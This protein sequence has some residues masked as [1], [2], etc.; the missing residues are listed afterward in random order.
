VQIKGALHVHSALS[1]D[2]TMTIRELA[3]LYRRHG[4]HFIAITEHAEDLDE[5]DVETL[6]KRSRENSD[7][8]FCVIPGLEF[9]ASS[10]LHILGLGV[11][12]LFPQD[13]R[14]AVL[15]HIHAQGGVA[16]LAHPRR[17][18]WN[19][20]A[21][22]LRAI[23]AT[24][25]WNVGYD[26]KFLPSAKAFGGFAAMRQVN[27]KLLAMAG[28][29]LH[30]RESFYDAAME[31][32]VSSLSAKEILEN[33]RR[34]RYEIRSRFFRAG[35]DGQVSPAKAKCLRVV[36]EQLR[37]VRRARSLALGWFS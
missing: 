37:H 17:I 4:Y 28:H 16:V 7:E 35:P 25:I 24:E 19:C 21:E 32:N 22:I 27:P 8:H 18:G 6:R 12:R 13:D 36:S 34:G 20:P 5:A 31:M 2:G 15:E 10:E 14:L 3:D 33:L 30:R 9:S 23:D 29:D 1:G 11:T 26:G